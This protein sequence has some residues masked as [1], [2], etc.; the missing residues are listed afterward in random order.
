LGEQPLRRSRQGKNAANSQKIRDKQL[1]RDDAP[2]ANTKGS[3]Q[4]AI[5]IFILFHLISIT[6]WALPVNWP[7]VVGVRQITRPYMLWTGLFQTWDMFAPN[8]VPTNTYIKAVVITQN[9]HLRVWAFPRM[10]ELSLAKRYQKERYRKFLENMLLEQ[11]AA[12]LPDVVRHI[13]R[14]YN[15]PADPPEKVMLIKFQADITPGSGDRPEPKPKP[16]DLYEEY[17]G[18]EDLR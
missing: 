9:H 18:P 13:A 14:F 5:S 17:L 4:A 12:L 8:P 6:C 16:S 10:D 15:D 11:N 3:L 2:K 1:N 7:L